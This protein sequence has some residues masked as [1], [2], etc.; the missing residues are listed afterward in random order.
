MREIAGVNQNRQDTRARCAANQAPVDLCLTPGGRQV[1][2][3]GVNRSYFEN[4]RKLLVFKSRL[5]CRETLARFA[6][7]QMV[8]VAALAHETDQF[9]ISTTKEA[10]AE[11]EIVSTN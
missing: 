1:D 6:A 7:C 9:F 11:A 8:A 10:P 4:K 2:S 5:L 3:D